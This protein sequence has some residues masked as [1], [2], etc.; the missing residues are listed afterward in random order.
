MGA[1]TVQEQSISQ[2]PWDQIPVPKKL[3]KTIPQ[4]LA[5]IE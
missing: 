3:N 2:G 1:G 5:L 4:K